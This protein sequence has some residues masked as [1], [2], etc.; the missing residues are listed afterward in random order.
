MYIYSFFPKWSV[1]SLGTYLNRSH[2]PAEAMNEGEHYLINIF[3][4]ENAMNQPHGIK[5]VLIKV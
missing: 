4:V 1:L 2:D 3:E 5:T